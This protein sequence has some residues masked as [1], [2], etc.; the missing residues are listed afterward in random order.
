V[1]LVLSHSLEDTEFH[2][3]LSLATNF[4]EIAHEYPTLKI[5]KVIV[6]VDT[7]RTA[8][9]KKMVLTGSMNSPE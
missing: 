4:K 9:A 8:L 3:Y 5:L 1:V 7:K 6:L 2:I